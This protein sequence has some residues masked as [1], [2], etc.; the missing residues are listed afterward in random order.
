MLIEVLL[1]ESEVDF[2]AIPVTDVRRMLLS[3][4]C[5]CRTGMAYIITGKPVTCR[6]CMLLAQLEGIRDVGLFELELGSSES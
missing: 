2:H 6:T 3:L 5:A 1:A 4:P